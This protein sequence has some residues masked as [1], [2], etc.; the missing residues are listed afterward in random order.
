[1]GA[2]AISFLKFRASWGQNGS[3]A[4]LSNYMYASNIVS[5]M[6]YPFVDGSYQVGSMP[7][8]TGNNNLKWET[9][10][11]LDFGL[12]LRMFDDRLAFTMDWYRK[13]TKDLIMSNVTS[14]LS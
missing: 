5:D 13:E 4:G 3:I 2:D 14:S 1:M 11:Q 12:D 10:E 6:Q 9:S 7:S 8:A